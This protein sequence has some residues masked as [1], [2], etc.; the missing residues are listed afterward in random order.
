MIHHT[1]VDY[2]MFLGTDGR[3]GL[4]T[5]IDLGFLQPRQDSNTR[6]SVCQGRTYPFDCAGSP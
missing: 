4:D 6:L 1:L 2:L 3:K 5:Y